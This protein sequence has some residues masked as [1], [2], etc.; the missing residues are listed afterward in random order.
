MNQVDA[1]TLQCVLDQNVELPQIQRDDEF[2]L[3]GLLYAL[4]HHTDARQV[5]HVQTAGNNLHRLNAVAALCHDLARVDAEPIIL[6]GASLLRLYPDVGCRSMEDVDLLVQTSKRSHVVDALE[7][8]G[9]QALPRHPDLFTRADGCTIDLHTDLLNGDRLTNR[10]RAGWIEPSQAWSRC[11]RRDVAGFQL[12]TLG[13]EDELLV[14]A[15]H[16]LRHS[17]RRL[18]WLIDLVLQLRA[19]KVSG[20]T[21]WAFAEA[22]GLYQP[23][24]YVLELVDGSQVSLPSWVVARRRQNPL[25]AW[26]VSVLGWIQVHRQQTVVGELLSCWTCSS[27]LDRLR[28]VAEFVFP[29]QDVLMQVFPRLPPRLAPL[30]YPLRLLQIVGRGV[31]EL[32][33]AAR[34]R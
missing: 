2:D 21:L 24:R 31:S 14:S 5:Q 11:Q 1:G 23:L 8:H 10:R 27:G 16:A 26:V 13:D 22:T 32:A 28:F 29:R 9:W 3:G 6:P 7:R 25:P 19:T 20:Q 4:G 17:Y 15:A 30:E 34:R 12:L 33:F 18:T